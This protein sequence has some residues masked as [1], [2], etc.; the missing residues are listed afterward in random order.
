MAEMDFNF[1]KYAAEGNRLI[2]QVA[3]RTGEPRNTARASRIVRTVLHG[4]RDAMMPGEAADVMSQLPLVV[5][6]VFADGWKVGAQPKRF[7]SEQEFIDYLRESA[8]DA[9]GRDFG[10]DQELTALVKEVIGVLEEDYWSEGQVDQIKHV[11]PEKLR[12]LF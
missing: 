3:E 5:K 8:G 9:A 7:R 12:S 2:K 11:L 10:N 1:E 4:V 6:G